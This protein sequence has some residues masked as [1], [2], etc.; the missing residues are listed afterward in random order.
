M[1]RRW[2]ALIGAAAMAA[3]T[4]A[5]VTAAVPASA[6]PCDPGNSPIVCENSKPGSPASEWEIAGNGDPGLQGFA[7]KFSVNVGETEQFKIKTTASSY[8][9]DIY[10]LGWYGGMGARKVASV[11][12][13]ARTQPNCISDSTTGLVDCGNWAVSASWAVPS[14]AVSG[15]YI[16]HLVNPVNLDSSQMT[17]VVRNDASHSDV[18][19]QTSDSAW[20]AYNVYGGSDFYA[21]IPAGRAYKLSYNRPFSTRGSESGRDFLFSNEFPMLQ[22]LERNGYDVSYMGSLDT[23]RRGSLLLNHKTFV[24]T[25]HDEYWSGQQRTNVEAARNAGVNLAFFSGNEVFWKT[26]WEPSIDGTATDGRTLVCYKETWANAKIDPTPAWTGTWRD[27]RFSPPSDGGR[28]ENGLTGTAY[29]SNFTDLPITVSEREGKL[30]LWRNTSLANLPVGSSAALADH[31]IGYESDEDLDNGFRPQGLVRLSTTTGATPQYLQDYGNTVAPGTTSHHLTE[32]RASSGALVFGAGTIQWAWG[33]SQN[34]DGVGAAADPRIQQATI[35]ILADMGATAATVMSGL[36]AST[37]SADTQGPTTVITSP[38]AGT[39][40]A[41]GT[42]ITATGTASDNGGGKVAGVEVSTDGGATWHPATGQGSWTYT[43]TLSGRGAVT[44]KVRAVDDSANIGAAASAAVTVNCPCSLFGD[45]LPATPSVSDTSA[46]ELGVQFTPADTGYVTAIRFYKGTGNTGTHTGSLWTSAGQLLATGTFTNETGTGW[47]TLQL[48]QSVPVNG[49][50][51]YVVSYFAP[52][53]HYAADSGFFA[54]QDYSAPPLSAKGRP[55]GVSNGVYSSGHS[56]PTSTY[57]NTNYYVDVQFSVDD[58][59]PPVVTGQSPLPGSTSVATTAKPRAVFSR[60]ITQSSLTFTLTDAS[61]A[62][63]P[64]AVTYDATSLAATFTPTGPLARGA[65]YT[66][67]VSASSAYGVP[68]TVPVTWSFTIALTDPLPGSC[69]CSIWTDSTIP[70]VASVS[71]TGNVELGV[72]FTADVDGEIAGIKFY[73]GPG[74]VGTHTGSLWTSTGTQLASATFVGESTTGWQTVLFLTPVAV[75]ANTTYIASYRAPVGGYAATVN[76]LASPVNSGPLHTLAGGAVYTYGTGFPTSTSSTNYW[77][78]VVYNARDAAP[79][80]AS[81]SP[82]SDATNVPTSQVVTASLSGQIQSSTPKLALK[83]AANA[84][85]AGTSTYTDSSKTASFTANAPLASGTTYTA[86]V[87]GAAALSGAVMSPYSW[88]FTTAGP[89]ACPCTLFESTARPAT[90]DSGDTSAISL[91][92]KF[93]PSMTSYAVGVRFYKSTANTGT[94]TV[95]IW[96]SAGV[97]LGMAT[98]TGE[99]AAG[100]QTAKFGQPVQLTSGQQY[101]A[102]YY[103]PNGHYSASGGFFTVPWTNGIL[104]APVSAGT[105]RYGGD[106]FPTDTYNAANYWVDPIVQP[107]SAPDTSPPVVLSRSPIAG[108][109]SVPVGVAP[110]AVFSEDITT[111]SL[112]MTLKTSAGAAVAASTVYDSASRT[113]TLTPN[114]GLARGTTYTETVSASDLAGNAMTPVSSVFT[115]AQPSP[116]PGVCPCSLWDDAATPAVITV[117]DSAT[118][119]LGIKF[120]TDIAGSITGVRFY[121]GPQNVGIHTGSLWS[122]SG[123]R[124]A[125]GT[126]TGESSTGWQTLAFASP[127]AVTAGTTYMASYLTSGYYSATGGG[128]AA[129]DRSPLH[130]GSNPAAYVYGGGYPTNPSSANYWVDPVFAP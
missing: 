41:N 27:P 12:P 92:V 48:A 62:I 30:R 112:T 6:A 72:K 74:N 120:S 97:R 45:K 111:S 115:T 130:T 109:T 126:F 51:T 2:V 8:T 88:S 19:F 90:I 1:K 68:M 102:S 23:D 35:N 122:T 13:I 61:S 117:N 3:S 29:M 33:L 69:P 31:T 71:D 58:T 38:A 40:L 34:H 55:S 77:V 36:V 32:Y 10:R 53:G 16:A 128:V 100:W 60:A 87:S 91:G 96:S 93:T 124:L 39:T 94:H 17:F 11:T 110:T 104:G 25:G 7:T 28:P 66:V 59:T 89:T 86:T 79:A 20:Q 78:D 37:T 123:T 63:I 95:S 82:G 125:T 56:F 65:T 24:S 101:T 103:A 129:I 5:T 42:T 22:F 64:G 119:E 113:A 76:G 98:V 67:T 108:A 85:V 49:G 43:F 81:T 106:A 57:G 114:V 47:Q 14:D 107:G 44:L 26:R 121:K 105:Y 80:V 4:L 73:K 50:A 21:G 75:T 15:V 18:L 52:N 116:Q 127:V 70:A 99:S 83:D 84:V 46:V 9:V 118:V 54:A